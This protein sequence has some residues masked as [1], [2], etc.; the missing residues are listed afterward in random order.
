MCCGTAV[1][2]RLV[3]VLRGVLGPSFELCSAFGNKTQVSFRCYRCASELLSLYNMLFLAE[4][5]ISGISYY[6]DRNSYSVILTSVYSTF[7]L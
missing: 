1:E 3:L 6:S 7:L 5:E 2:F 4:R